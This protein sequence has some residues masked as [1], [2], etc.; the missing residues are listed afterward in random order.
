MIFA[1]LRHLSAEKLIFQSNADL[2]SVSTIFEMRSSP[3][4]GKT[5]IPE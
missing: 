2:L 1:P 4:C 5:H 3:V